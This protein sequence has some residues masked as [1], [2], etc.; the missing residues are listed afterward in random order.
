MT[1][2]N[3]KAWRTKRGSRRL[4]RCGGT[5]EVLAPK[6]KIQIV[7]AKALIEKVI[8]SIQLAAL[9]GRNGDGRIFVYN[10]D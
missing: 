5:K 10:I 7:L 2:T 4:S 6:A 9:T 8:E 3:S 1:D